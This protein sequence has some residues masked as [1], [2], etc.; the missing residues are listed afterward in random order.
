MDMLGTFAVGRQVVGTNGTVW[1]VTRDEP[2]GEGASASVYEGAERGSGRPVAIK[3]VDRFDLDDDP[4]AQEKLEREL[5]ISVRLKH[6]NIINLLDVVFE[7]QWVMLVIAN[8]LEFE[9]F[10]SLQ[11]NSIWDSARYCHLHRDKQRYRR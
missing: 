7:E 5:Q 8:H 1:E 3:A 9:N 4:Q 2:L 10:K 6:A 11:S